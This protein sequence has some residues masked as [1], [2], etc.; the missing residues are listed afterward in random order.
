MGGTP[1]SKEWSD[2]RQD[3]YEQSQGNQR[4]LWV[5]EGDAGDRDEEAHLLIERHKICESE[6][7]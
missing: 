2:S 1:H 3:F 7:E 4:E 5:M 6:G